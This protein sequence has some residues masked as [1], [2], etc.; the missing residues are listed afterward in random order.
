MLDGEPTTC[1]TLSEGRREELQDIA[2][3]A[4]TSSSLVMD[5]LLAADVVADSQGRVGSLGSKPRAQR[6]E[7]ELV[8]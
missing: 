1:D 7:K 5:A 8:P 3:I 2:A 6:P 4:D